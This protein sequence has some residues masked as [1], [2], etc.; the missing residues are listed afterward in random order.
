M[1]DKM[2]IVFLGVFFRNPKTTAM[3]PNIAFLARN[4]MTS[5]ILMEIVRD[6]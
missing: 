6:V 2:K 1:A 4:T 3:L 5:V